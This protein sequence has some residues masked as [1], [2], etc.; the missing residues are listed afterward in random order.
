MICLAKAKRKKNENTHNQEKGQKQA[1]KMMY[2]SKRCVQC[3]MSSFFIK[4]FIRVGMFGCRH[5]IV[6][7]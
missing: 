4:L 1:G 5:D 3:F 6:N 2:M 7:T